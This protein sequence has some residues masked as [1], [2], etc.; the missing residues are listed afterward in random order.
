MSDEQGEGQ[1]Q[2]VPAPQSPTGSRGAGGAE[3][4]PRQGAEAAPAGLSVWDKIQLLLKS[5]KFWALVAALALL[6]PQAE[7]EG[8]EFVYASELVP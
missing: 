2:E 5:R 1:G 6:M 3:A 4:G 8:I 7:K